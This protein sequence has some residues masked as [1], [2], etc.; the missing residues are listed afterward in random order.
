MATL[1]TWK[2]A[3]FNDKVCCSHQR[4][5]NKSAFFNKAG[6]EQHLFILQDSAVPLE[7]VTFPWHNEGLRR[8]QLFACV[9]RLGLAFKFGFKFPVGDSVPVTVRNSHIK[10]LACQ[11]SSTHILV[12]PCNTSNKIAKTWNKNWFPPMLIQNVQRSLCQIFIEL[13]WTLMPTSATCERLF[14]CAGF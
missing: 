14:C 3:F 6:L 7:I 10:T 2:E 4:C 5:T 9:K 8:R 11:H 1:R 13:N 12:W